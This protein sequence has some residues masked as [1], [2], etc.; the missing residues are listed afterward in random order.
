MHDL[1]SGMTAELFVHRGVIARLA[2]LGGRPYE[3]GGW[4][5]G[6]WA[7]DRSAVF[8]THVTPPASVGTPAGVRISGEG[9]RKR[10]DEAWEATGGSV[11]YLGDWHTH[12]GGPALPSARDRKA[13]RQL[14]ERPSYGT[15]EPLML[16]VATPRWPGGSQPFAV[17]FHLGGASGH[18]EQLEPG[19][20]EA[21]PSPSDA[22]PDWPWPGRRP[23]RR[24]SRQ[25]TPR[26]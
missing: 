3:I 12:P 8:L 7:Q 23:G 10:F 21:L 22:V 6:Y 4:L 9:H 25:S 18:L 24:P 20:V 16:I 13:M 19:L 11:T 26:V 2:H 15:P 14:A 1:Q 5:L 17:T